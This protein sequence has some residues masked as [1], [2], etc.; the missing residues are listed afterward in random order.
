MFFLKKP[1]Y[2]CNLA[3]NIRFDKIP[4]KNEKIRFDII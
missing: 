1:M 4:F 3:C 2:Q